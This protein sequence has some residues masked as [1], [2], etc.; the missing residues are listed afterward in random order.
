[1]SRHAP[2]FFCL[3]SGRCGSASLVR[4]LQAN[5]IRNCYHEL[6][7]DLHRLG[8]DYYELRVSA[9]E[10]AATIR[11]TRAGVFFE[12]N[13]RLFSLAG[14][15][16]LAFPDAKFIFLHRDGREVVRSGL[17]RQ[18]YQEGDRFRGIRLGS[19]VVGSALVK[20]CRYW[21][22]VNQRI[23]S[24]M[25]LFGCTHL[26]LRFD[27]LRWGDG[28]GRLEEFL[29]VRLTRCAE[30]PAA[31]G[32]PTWSV[33]AY[34]DWSAQWQREF[35][36]ICGPVMRLLGYETSSDEAR[37]KAERCLTAPAQS[38]AT[39]RDRDVRGRT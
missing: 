7:P 29:G 6:S 19:A 13:N 15:I 9:E 14:P 26:S 5:N 21:A 8:I 16:R 11:R 35:N 27:E 37:T 20:T 3:N 32:T 17:Q 25:R 1:M 34:E 31:N 30:L 39:A 2:I 10:A 33:P 12:A 22:E 28:L 23:I 36:E 38:P 18:W 4:L 24:D